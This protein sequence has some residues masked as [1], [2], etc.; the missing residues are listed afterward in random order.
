MFG[1]KKKVKDSVSMCVPMDTMKEY[2][3]WSAAQP[4]CDCGRLKSETKGEMWATETQCFACYEKN[5]SPEKRGM[6]S[7]RDQALRAGVVV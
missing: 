2:K 3:E 5:G 7:A 6:D 4:C 1:F